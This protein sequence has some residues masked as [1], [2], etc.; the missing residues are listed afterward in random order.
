MYY[1]NGSLMFS[2]ELSFTL[3]AAF[4]E[5]ANRRHAYFCVEHLLFALLFDLS[6]K[7]VILNCGGDIEVLKQ[8]LE[9][10]FDEHLEKIGDGDAISSD[11]VSSPQI[12]SGDSA[13]FFKSATNNGEP[14]QTP[15]VQRV[16]QAAILLTR[17]SGKEVITSK[18]LL[19]SLYTESDSHAVYFLKRQGID[20]ID[21]LSFV[22]HGTSKLNNFAQ[23]LS[24][25]A[26]KSRSDD[27]ET[28]SAE[29]EYGEDTFARK[30]ALKQF[31]ENLTL[32]ARQRQLDPVIGRDEEIERALKILSRRQKN[33][34]LFLGDPGVGK[35]AMAS[36][37]AQRIVAGD[38]PEALKGA[39]LYTLSVGSLIAGTKFRGEFEDRLRRLI[40]EI[41]QSKTA[42]ILFIDEIHTIVGAGAT[43]TGS[44]DAA[45]LLKPALAS[46]KIRCIG[47][48]THEDFKKS[49]EKDRALS[50][51]FS[52]IDLKEP[53]IEE[54]I[55]IL[56]GL[57]LQFEEHHKVRYSKGALRAAAELSAKHINDKFLPDKAIDVIDEA[58]AANAMPGPLKRKRVVGEA[59]IEA[60]VASISKVPVK[61]VKA[62]EE[63][64]LLNLD[65]KLKSRVFGQDRAIFA[66]SRSIKRS[67]AS[68]KQD[69][70]PVGSFLFAGPTGVGKTE[71]ARV[72]AAELGVPFHKLDMSEYMEKHSVARLTGAP[73]GYVG[74]E[75]GG[76]LTDLIRR[77]PFSVLLLDEIEKAHP[78]A[79][80][81]LLQIMDDAVLTDS[82]GK[83]ADFRNVILIMTTNAGSEKSAAIGFGRGQS[84]GSDKE[85]IKKTFRPEFRNRLDD[86]VYFDSLPE[87]V[88]LQVVDKF[89]NELALQL[90]TRNV[91]IVISADARSWMAKRGFDPSMGARPMNRL[92][93]TEIKDPLSDE[94]LFG[95]LKKG[96]QVIVDL[97]SDKL[98]FQISA[99]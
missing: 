88:V 96:G 77:E 74:Y 90:A 28:F 46:G 15:A 14:L 48:S 5:A 94:L 49:F 73:P 64:L 75:E 78:D 6:A 39:E 30:G 37:L 3:E 62:S 70:K 56:E 27:E 51:R 29:E 67:R 68:L 21:V 50:R 1:G 47:S 95:N 13:G 99:S 63:E 79:F 43:G 66:I 60:V 89:I 22:S 41:S 97:D 57:K 65:S 12:S 4:K 55:K 16:L 32:L 33:N 34:P 85:A 19:I 23:G 26:E 35:T 61:T 58:G 91:Q 8:E 52:V 24:S 11:N 45:N 40:N 38:V 20:K 36:A 31:T 10:F 17:S 83:K 69:N 9:E 59:E 80:N 25:S 18:E 2:T 93:Q 42:T 53:G 98:S 71:L 81:I 82:H 84:S 86:V 76:I 54:T 92:I 44:M 72:L 87:D 7:E